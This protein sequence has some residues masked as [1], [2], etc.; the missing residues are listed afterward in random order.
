MDTVQD[1]TKLTEEE[2]AK[3]TGSVTADKVTENVTTE[4]KENVA[5][6]VETVKGLGE[7]DI[8][9]RNAFAEMTKTIGASIVKNVSAQ[10][11]LLSAPMNSIMNENKEGGGLSA[12]LLELRTTV[13]SINPN[14]YDLS[15]SSFRRLLSK[16]PG[17]GTKLEAWFSKYQSVASVI[18]DILKNLECGKE[19]LL[20]DNKT[21]KFDRDTLL[22]Y[23][24]IL[25]DKLAEAKLL[26]DELVK[27]IESGEL[28]DKK[29]IEEDVL[30][31]LR[32]EEQD[33]TL[34]LGA[35]NQAI[36]VSQI[37]YKANEELIRSSD[38]T[39]NVTSVA[40]KS[41]AAM[42]IALSHQ[43]SQLQAVKSVNDM[44]TDLL[45]GTAKKAKEQGTA[46]V[47]EANDISAQ[48]DGMKEA[49][50]DCLEA[51]NILDAYKQEALPIMKENINVLSDLNGKMG[52]AINR[53]N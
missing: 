24:Y 5:K 40:L 49:F 31:Y 15:M 25:T 16:L 14:K 37:I 28:A 2:I 26:D 35:A 38:R 23:V 9:G 33:M 13:E 45:K 21:L 27:L 6:M 12:S 7:R 50:S 4:V 18:D 29:F 34:M 51:M 10:S 3:E 20:K 1:V 17:V 47:K 52:E 8:D 44:T 48:I 41:A 22:K 32:Q 11:E 19:T 53:N 43:Q 39:L 30:Y 42:E 36:M 46:I